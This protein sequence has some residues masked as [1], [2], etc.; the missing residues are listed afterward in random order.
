MEP[1]RRAE[2]TSESNDINGKKNNISS[3]RENNNNN[4]KQTEPASRINQ[5]A[6]EMDSALMDASGAVLWYSFEQ[7][8]ASGSALS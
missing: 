5:V 1:P 2:D 7:L 4:N 6:F 3:Q 8:R